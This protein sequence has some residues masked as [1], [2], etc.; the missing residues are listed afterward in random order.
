MHYI[1]IWK[2]LNIFQEIKKDTIYILI[3]LLY[4]STY[5]RRDTFS[6][7]F[8]CRPCAK[9]LTPKQHDQISVF[10]KNFFC[11]ILKIALDIKCILCSIISEIKYHQHLATFYKVNKLKIISKNLLYYNKNVRM[12]WDLWPPNNPCIPATK[13]GLSMVSAS[14][15]Q[16]AKL[17]Q[18]C[19][20]VP[21]SNLRCPAAPSS[22]PGQ[23]PG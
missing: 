5:I 4:N 6:H 15:L 12:S 19:L 10:K 17:A 3:V 23:H 18:M 1:G 22:N 2:I 7:K 14:Q 21:S 9:N 20:S 11:V 13:W 8:F 16:V